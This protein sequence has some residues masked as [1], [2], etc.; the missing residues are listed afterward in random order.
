MLPNFLVVGAEKAGTST[1]AGM[2]AEHPDVFM[3][4]PK[5]PRFF[6]HNW[7][8]GLH[9]YESLFAG[10]GNHQAIGEASPAYTWAPE[11]MCVPQRIHQCL[12][13]IRYLY[14]VRNPIERMI[15]H[16]RHALV[17]RWIPDH[18]SFETALKLR[19]G[20][21]NC[22]RYFYQIEQY[23]PYTSRKQWHVVVLEEM[24]QDYQKDADGV[25][26]FLGIEKI[27]LA[28]LQVRNISDEKGRPP[29]LLQCL[30]PLPDFLPH[31]CLEFVR[32]LSRKLGK[33]IPKPE[34][35]EGLRN[36]L[37]EEL[38]PD[39]HKLG[40]FCGRDFLTIWGIR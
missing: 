32:K 34:I 21:K 33:K 7:S 13:N 22:S 14:I 4:D 16:Y 27:P 40:D 12:G 29:L 15:S 6:S 35:T 17:Y 3:C 8:K 36:A 23:L 38:K 2:L 28:R 10:A 18:T 19:P 20:L 37:W 31:S 9:W 11:S 1:F 26:R 5:E 25:F 24:M 30:R 39:V